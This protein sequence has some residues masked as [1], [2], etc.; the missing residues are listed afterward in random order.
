MAYTLTNRFETLLN[1]PEIRLYVPFSDWFEAKRS[2]VWFQINRKKVN[3]IWFQVDLIRFRKDFSVCMIAYIWSCIYIYT[4]YSMMWHFRCV[5]GVGNR[6]CHRA[7]LQG[8]W[9]FTDL[10]LWRVLYWSWIVIL[11]RVCLFIIFNGSAC[12]KYVKRNEDLI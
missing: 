7:A 9:F 11:A 6:L 3:S 8:D 5:T 10:I 12:L 4:L 1:Q 2:S